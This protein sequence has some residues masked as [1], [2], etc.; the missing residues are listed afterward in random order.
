MLVGW[1]GKVVAGSTST[2]SFQKP[3]AAVE[4]K[5]DASLDLTLLSKMPRWESAGPGLLYT[6]R[7]T[8][9]DCRRTKVLAL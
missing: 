7:H 3:K 9:D 1:E 5:I 8:F 2:E 4:L 6:V